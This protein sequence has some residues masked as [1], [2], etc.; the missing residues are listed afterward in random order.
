MR[1]FF[2]L[3]LSLPLFAKTI[4]YGDIDHDGRDES[5]ELIS[6]GQTD[7]GSFYQ[8]IVKDDNGRVLWQ[9][10]KSLNTNNRYSFF[11]AHH[12]ISM[13]EIL[14]DIDQDGY[15]ELIA[16]EP[17]SDVSP[18]YYRKL[19]W[20]AKRFRIMPSQAL[21]ME[22]GNVLRWK[23]SKD[24][25]GVWVSSFVGMQRG[26]IKANI[27]SYIKGEYKSGVALLEPTPK[28]ARV[29]EWIKALGSG[30]HT[31]NKE[32]TRIEEPYTSSSSS[33]SL[34][35]SLKVVV[36]YSP[37]AKRKLETH[38]E[39]VM[40]SFIIDQYGKKYMQVEGVASK[41]VLF[42]TQHDIFIKKMHFKT[43]HYDPKKRYKLTLS[44]FSASKTIDQN[45][46]ECY[47]KE[48]RVD[49][50]I[51]DIQGSTLEY[52][53]RLIGEEY[54]HTQTKDKIKKLPT[55]KTT[56]TPK[57]KIADPLKDIDMDELFKP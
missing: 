37:K 54:T 28:G 43:A 8:L 36:N 50:E 15:M 47:D 26:L 12:G 30:D 10:R 6:S 20:I 48:H 49:F 40:A 34:E 2:I 33:R 44:I 11:E 56:T 3:L 18:T 25:E 57:V 55:P 4:L 5:M 46:L 19:K 31:S 45:I 32:D 39:K 24:Y 51:G 38:N 13:P 22:R 23:N 14:V 53:C 9:A 1:I 7:M 29:V 21:M 42:D 52:V 35:L 17:Q 41:D 16:P 27:T